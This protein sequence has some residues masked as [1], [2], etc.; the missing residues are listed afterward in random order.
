MSNRDL[1]NAYFDGEMNEAEMQDFLDKVE[2]SSELKQEF[3]LQEDI[4]NGI[5]SVRKA[6]L[7]A[8]LDNISVG[9]GISN[10]AL[11][12][13]VAAIGS[14]VILG[15]LTYWY[16]SADEVTVAESIQPKEVN[17]KVED[18]IPVEIDEQERSDEPV[19]EEIVMEAVEETEISERSSDIEQQPVVSA[20]S[21]NKPEAV[22]PLEIIDEEEELLPDDGMTTNSTATSTSLEVEI[23]DSK[24]RY[25]F[26]YQ[27][28]EGRLFLFGTFDKGLYE[29]LEFNSPEGKVLFLYYKDKYY[30]INKNQHEVSALQE[31]REVTLL[32]KLDE[33][34][35]TKN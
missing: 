25:S 28:K 15:A 20:P 22:D 31:V 9:G 33:A 4:I 10:G 1:I 16:N 23:D 29:I 21:I 11:L 24:K 34:R 17:D 32:K 14:I 5:K 13:K 19:S 18:L 27:M 7:K 6:E 12:G 2:G 30:G 26:H 3:T 8:R 35:N